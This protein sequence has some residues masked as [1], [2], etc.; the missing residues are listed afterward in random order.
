MGGVRTLTWDGCHNVRDLGGLPVAGGGETRFGSVVRADSLRELTG[1]GWAQALDYGVLRVV[2]LRFS[3]ERARDTSS[4]PPVEVVHV[5]LFG[6]HDPVAEREW[7]DRGRATLSATDMFAHSY[8]YTVEEHIPSVVGAVSAVAEIDEGC[9]A[10]HCF[11]GKDRTGIVAALLLSMAGVDDETIG[12]DYAASDPG[13]MVLLGSWIAAADN[14][15]ERAFR[16][17]VATSPAEAM[18]RTLAHVRARWGG[19]EEYLVTHGVE[20]DSL[21]RLRNRL[22]GAA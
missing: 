11:G 20:P 22:V 2:D 7:G 1:V 6:E 21:T 13:L 15:V 8:T 4:E 17:R 12:R 18:T 14:S 5:S 19:A 16:A 3:E 10:I 9:V